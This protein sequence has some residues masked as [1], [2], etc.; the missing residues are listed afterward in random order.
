MKNAPCK[1]VDFMCVLAWG[2]FRK[3]FW[4]VFLA[5]AGLIDDHL[6]PFSTAC[7]HLTNLSNGI[8]LPNSILRGEK[9]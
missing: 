8:K 6:D 7:L 2:V 5:I 1:M 9:I 4:S 3:P